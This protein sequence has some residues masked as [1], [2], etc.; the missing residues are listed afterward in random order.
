[1]RNC[2]LTI[3]GQKGSGKTTFARLL[4]VRTPRA[5]VVDRFQEYD[6]A[7]VSSFPA[8]LDYLAANWRGRFRLACRFYQDL[9]HREL[10]R[11]IILTARRCPTL[12]IALLIEE[13]DFFADPHGIE[14]VVDYLYKY[15]RH[16]QLNIVSIARGDTDLHRSI[17]NNTDCF[18]IFRQRRF[19]GNMR[20][21]F[22][23]SDLAHLPSLETLTPNVTPEKGVHFLTYPPEADPFALW[24]AANGAGSQASPVVPP[25]LD[26][27]PV[28]R[29]VQGTHPAP[30][31]DTPNGD[32]S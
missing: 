18:I 6:G 27:A 26:T 19:S 3:L 23:P 31:T 30:G 4:L 8:A 16:W 32:G 9:H 21:L 13:A 7:A 14:P 1:M 29:Y 28:G 12:P 10:F 22:A 2:T 5:V 17:I 24:A 11:Y 25:A 15:G 20:N